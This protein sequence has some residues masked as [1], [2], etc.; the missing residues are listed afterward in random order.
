MGW[1]LR[2]G[3]R[4]LYRNRRVNG[5]PVKEYLGPD[6]QFGFGA[7]LA[8]NL[9]HVQRRAAKARALERRADAEFRG[10][11]GVLLAAAGAVNA[12]LRVIAEGILTA[13]GFHN[14]KR[15]EWRMRRGLKHLAEQIDLLEAQL[16]KPGPLVNY[17]APAGDAEAIE[18]F[19]KARAG[20]AAAL[21]RV[22]GVIAARGWTGWLGDIGQQATRQLI[23]AAAANDP[24]WE[25]GITEKVAALRRELLGP[26]PTALDDLLVRR[27]VN[28]WVA[29]HALELELAVRPPGERKARDYL[30]RALT[31]AQK[32]MT[33]AARELAR[34]RRLSVPAVLTRAT[35]TP[36]PAIAPSAPAA[37]PPAPWHGTGG[38]CG[39]A[40]NENAPIRTAALAP[41]GD[42]PAA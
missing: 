7:E 17:Q 15:G 26:N 21:E 27:V 33:D 31:R 28:G 8:D 20:D 42:D 24:V 36:P 41:Q 29:V 37:L 25:A 39:M 38:L 19:A 9:T 13:V 40:G 2:G 11:I 3:R 4:Y 32:R 23:R 16:A 35:I 30:D 12:A 22:R 1:E 14:H 10:R 34:L 18:M 6:D 5:K